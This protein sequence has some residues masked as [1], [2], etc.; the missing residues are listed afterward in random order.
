MVAAPASSQALLYHCIPLIP[1]FAVLSSSSLSVSIQARIL[2]ILCVHAHYTQEYLSHMP[3]PMI[4]RRGRQPPKAVTRV[5]AKN[6]NGKQA[7]PIAETPVDKGL[8][9]LE[10]A[11]TELLA[12]SYLH[13]ACSRICFAVL[14]YVACT[15]IACGGVACSAS[16]Y[17]VQSSLACTC[18]CV[19][20]RCA[21]H[22]GSVVLWY[23]WMHIT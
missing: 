6:R 22:T 14:F 5:T 16:A 13:R 19:L 21:L 8:R 3:P 10:S 11:C 2:C 1:C 15:A 23:E 18:S 9:V 20:S 4:G 17:A 12:L 7:R